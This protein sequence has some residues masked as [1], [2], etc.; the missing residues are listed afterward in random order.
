MF[1]P[2][3]SFLTLASC[4]S[5]YLILPCTTLLFHSL[6]FFL[7]ATF[8]SSL[9]QLTSFDATLLYS[10][11]LCSVLYMYPALHHSALPDSAVI[12]SALLTILFSVTFLPIY[13]P[14]LCSV[15]LHIINFPQYS[16]TCTCVSVE[17]TA[18]KTESLAQNVCCKLCVWLQRSL[19]SSSPSLES[20]YLNYHTCIQ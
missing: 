9:F 12:Y 1:K 13:S 3:L 15:L 11:W 5:S 8:H 2:N 10:A 16:A 4:V 19:M 14:S 18:G 20:K 6:V 17:L 7:S